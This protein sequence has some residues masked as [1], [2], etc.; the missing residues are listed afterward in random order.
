V[1]VIK[2]G[3]TASIQWKGT[4][5][6]LDFSCAC[7]GSGHVDGE[8]VYAIQCADCGTTY[9]MPRTV[10]LVITGARDDAFIPS[11]GMHGGEV[12]L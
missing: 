1:I 4:D 2:V 3:A 8:F 5:V 11:D 6:C 10:Q 12:K 9:A 7:G